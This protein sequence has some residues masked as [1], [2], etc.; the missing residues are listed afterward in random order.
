MSDYNF[1]DLDEQPKRMS[2]RVLKGLRSGLT[3]LP[4]PSRESRCLMVG[5]RAVCRCRRR[6]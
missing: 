1:A 4:F 3:K 6:Y 2:P 5:A